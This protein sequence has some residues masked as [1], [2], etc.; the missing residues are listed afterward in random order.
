MIFPDLP[1][2]GGGG[3]G[4]GL[5]FVPKFRRSRSL[6]EEGSRGCFLCRRARHSSPAAP[7]AGNDLRSSACRAL[8]LE[9]SD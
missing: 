4:A 2:E 5:G 3:G 8:V 6:C 1:P 7:R 9:L